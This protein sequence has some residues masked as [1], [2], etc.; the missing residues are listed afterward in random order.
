MIVRLDDGAVVP[1]AYLQLL[2]ALAEESCSKLCDP[3]PNP[4]MINNKPMEA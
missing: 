4:S 1:A 3:P 2:K